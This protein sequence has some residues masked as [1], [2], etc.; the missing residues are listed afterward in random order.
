MESGSKPYLTFRIA[1]KN[2]AVEACRVR[3]VLPVE[4]LA[5]FPGAGPEILGF[6]SL[7]GRAFAVLDLPGKLGLSRRA[8]GRDPRIVAVSAGDQLAGVLADRVSD[9]YTYYARDLRGGVLHGIGRPR[10][11]LQMEW[12]ADLPVP[13][14]G[15][16]R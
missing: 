7:R 1:N 12:L 2:F 6:A 16:I 3:G 14:I 8:A 4:D 9:I 5:P 10:R 13:R 11:L 15:L